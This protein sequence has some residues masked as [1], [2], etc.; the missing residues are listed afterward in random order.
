MKGKSMGPGKMTSQEIQQQ[1]EALSRNGAAA[2]CHYASLLQALLFP[3]AYTAELADL[4]TILSA[5]R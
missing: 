2:E 3:S 5:L 4:P 1:I